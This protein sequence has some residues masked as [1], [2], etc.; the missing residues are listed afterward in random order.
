MDFAE[1]IRKSSV[2]ENRKVYI[3][4]DFY[5]MDF[6]KSIVILVKVDEMYNI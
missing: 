4:L 6:M 1:H 5:E 3:L 2:S